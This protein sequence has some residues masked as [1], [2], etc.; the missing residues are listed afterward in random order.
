MYYRGAI[1]QISTQVN[2]ISNT[3][4]SQQSNKSKHDNSDGL[5][6]ESFLSQLP[7]DIQEAFNEASVGLDEETKFKRAMKLSLNMMKPMFMMFSDG[8]YPEQMPSSVK[9]ALQSQLKEY[10]HL[11]SERERN[12]YKLT[13]MI[14][15][16]DHNRSSDSGY[17]DFLI[18][19]RNTYNADSHNTYKSRDQINESD[20]ELQKFKDDLKTKG[21][22]KFLYE[23][24]LEK[25]EK[26]V[27]EYRDKLLEEMKNNP[28]LDIDIE[29]MVSSYKK[30]LLERLSDLED[31][32]EKSPIN[33]KNLEFTV[34][35]NLSTKLEDLLQFQ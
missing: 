5:S 7:Q 35:N 26:M 32:N 13:W 9:H 28:E 15:K 14:E 19:M 2:Q 17:E 31:S 27:E 10:Q 20:Y 8:N 25:I 22:V 29:E 12:I 23:F 21:A 18:D 16:I 1:M 33:I 34:A 4:T 30:E 24:N 11:G 6:T 3:I